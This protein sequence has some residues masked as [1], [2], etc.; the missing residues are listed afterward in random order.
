[1]HFVNGNEMENIFQCFVFMYSIKFIISERDKSTLFRCEQ[2]SIK[3]ANPRDIGHYLFHY[4]CYKGQFWTRKVGLKQGKKKSGDQILLFVLQQNL[5]THTL[6]KHE[7][8]EVKTKNTKV[9]LYLPR[10]EPFLLA[11]MFHDYAHARNSAHE[12]T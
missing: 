2:V 4:G 5:N 11:H 12:C 3:L 9:L 6:R 8:D 1:M 7:Q 10:A